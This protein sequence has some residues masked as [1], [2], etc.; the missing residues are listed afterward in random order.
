MI[1]EIE[2]EPYDLNSEVIVAENRVARVQV[3]ASRDGGY[4]TEWY[5]AAL[6][7]FVFSNVSVVTD[8]E[9]DRAC[10]CWNHR[11]KAF[12]IFAKVKILNSTCYSFN[13]SIEIPLKRVTVVPEFHPLPGQDCTIDL[14]DLENVK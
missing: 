12:T 14:S 9:A 4:H 1:L 2:I 13:Q 3:I 8:T 11:A 7:D 10:I 6:P 5:L